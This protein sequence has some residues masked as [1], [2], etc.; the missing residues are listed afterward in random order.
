MDSTLEALCLAGYLILTLV[1][2]AYGIHFYMLVYLA[3]RRYRGVTRAQA[4]LINRYNRETPADRWPR[5]TTQIPLYNEVAVARRVIE[6]AAAMDYPAGRHE[7]QVLDDSTD[8]TRAVVDRV[9][10]ELRAK[11][12]DAKAIRRP[13]R[14]HYKAGALAYGLRSA[15]GDFIAIF[16]ADFIPARDFLRRMIPLIATQP[17]ACCAQA[18]W[19]HLNAE[20]N[21]LT[22]GIALGI[23]G[24]F[25]V[26]QS[27]RAWNG[28]LMNFNGTGGVWRRAAIEDPRVG[29]WSGD[30]ITEDLDL[31]YRAQ[32]AGWKIVYRRDEIC[33]AEVP[34]DVDAIKSQ[35]RRWATG[36]IQTAR[37]MIGPVWRSR[38]TLFQ[39]IEATIH[40]IQYSIAIFMVLIPLLARFLVMGLPLERYHA[41]LSWC[42]LP[43]IFAAAAPSI[44]YVYARYTLGGG[45]SGPL[46]IL[47]LMLLGL[48][49]SVNNCYAVLVGVVQRGGEFVR[50][51]KSGSTGRMDRVR[52]K[53]NYSAVRSNLW[54]I[55]VLFGTFCLAQW[56]YF[57]PEDRY[58]FGT[59]LLL[60]GVGLMALGWHSRPRVAPTPARQL[61]MATPSLPPPPEV[62]EPATG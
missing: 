1:P 32:L 20:E 16:D 18:R 36:S 26:E 44:A 51:P 7:I 17:D 8:D 9:C 14:T 24:H 59:F 37:K 45:V 29:G 31:S 39:K 54:L 52:P 43:I 19:G 12:I 62:A 40:L 48:G 28:L 15:S 6:A 5:V 4:E 49:L 57:L 60:Y 46:R 56:I 58:V 53:A 13:R 10:A 30:T 21:W 42:W 61:P 23:D 35:Q 47:K 3:H 33:P 22:E 50:T 27:A 34:A 55:E 11:G 38:L 2:A 41:W 25:G